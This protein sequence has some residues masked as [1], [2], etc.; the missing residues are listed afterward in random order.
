MVGGGFGA[1]FA[2][3]QGFADAVASRQT[4][5][6]SSRPTLAGCEQT[7][8]IADSTSGSKL[9]SLFQQ[10]FPGVQATSEGEPLEC[11]AREPE[12]AACKR[13]ICTQGGLKIKLQR[14]R[15]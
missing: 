1:A 3:P 2:L 7:K 8:S 5:S 4:A 11:S 14:A 9:N 13:Q 12:R 10:S 15:D 6:A